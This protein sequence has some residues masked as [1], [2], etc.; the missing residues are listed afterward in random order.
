[1]ATPHTNFSGWTLIF[2]RK[3]NESVLELLDITKKG[4][5]RNLLPKDPPETLHWV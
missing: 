5:L 1:M 3:F 4:V 2:H